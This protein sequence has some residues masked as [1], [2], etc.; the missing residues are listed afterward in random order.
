MKNICA[1]TTF[2]NKLAY[3]S[4]NTATGKLIP[5]DL[6]QYHILITNDNP[7]IL[8]LTTEKRLI[9]Q[10]LAEF[11]KQIG[12]GIKVYD[13]N[14]YVDYADIPIEIGRASCRERV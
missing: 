14:D 6:K 12:Y 3:E 8:S 5:K 7:D 13:E 10:A 2:G 4:D 1:L 9:R 11:E